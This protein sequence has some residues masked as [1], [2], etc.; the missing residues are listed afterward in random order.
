MAEHAFP[1]TGFVCMVTHVTIG[2]NLLFLIGMAKFVNVQPAMLY[3]KFSTPQHTWPHM[4]AFFMALFA[5]LYLFFIFFFFFFFLLKCLLLSCF[6]T[7]VNFICTI[8]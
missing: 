6:V 4:K 8:L 3:C 7:F 1:L 2:L 5:F